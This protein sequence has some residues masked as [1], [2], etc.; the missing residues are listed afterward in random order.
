LRQAIVVLP[1]A[2]SGRIADIAQRRWLS[3][4]ALSDCSEPVDLFARVLSAAGLPTLEEGLAALRLWGQTGDRPTVWIAAAD[5]VHLEARLNHVLLRTLTGAEAPKSELHALVEHLQKS[6]GEDS[7][8]AFA[9]VGK[10]AYLRGD[11]AIATASLS[12]TVIDGMEPTAFMPAGAA[13]AA[14]Q[15]LLSEAQMCLHDHEVNRRREAA[16]LLPINSVWFWGGGRAPQKTVR[17]LPPLFGDEPLLK[18]YWESCTGVVA[19][20][21]GN[22]RDCLEFALKDFVVVTPESAEGSDAL[23]TFLAELK[24][25]LQSG[26]LDRLQLLFRDGLNAGIGR[27]DAFRFWRRMSS[28]L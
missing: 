14:Y 10:L 21:P 25:M 8:F 11:E 16:G 2:K 17:V 19:P 28:L 7:G 13:A 4:A 6:L 15:T 22:F 18:G 27:F 24:A 26:Q 3:R 1:A 5:P 9:L 23:G 12:A 20:W